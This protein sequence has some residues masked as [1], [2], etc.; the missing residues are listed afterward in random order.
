MQAADAGIPR[1]DLVL[2]LDISSKAAGQRADFGEERYEKADFQARVAKNYTELRQED[3]KVGPE[4]LFSLN[5]RTSK[6]VL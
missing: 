1:P 3:W 2:Y 4:Q 5:L 6:Y